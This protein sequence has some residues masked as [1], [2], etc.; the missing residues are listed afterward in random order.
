MCEHSLID[1]TISVQ[2]GGVKGIVHL[3]RRR[4]HRSPSLSEQTNQQRSKLGA[5]EVSVS[6]C[7]SSS[8]PKPSFDILGSEKILF[9]RMIW[10]RDRHAGQTSYAF[11]ALISRESSIVN[12]TACTTL[13]DHKT[14]FEDF[15]VIQISYLEVL[16][17]MSFWEKFRACA[18][19]N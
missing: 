2:I 15:S 9:S 14:L 17:Q 6:A 5:N 16:A 8:D 13:S 4:Q 7:I 18:A 1:D 12:I 19:L 10:L 11:L 3:N